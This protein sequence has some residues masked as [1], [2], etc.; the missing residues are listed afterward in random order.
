MTK[1][2]IVALF[3]D[4]I[5]LFGNLNKC[6]IDCGQCEKIFLHFVYFIGR[7]ILMYQNSNF[8]P[9]AQGNERKEIIPRSKDE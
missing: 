1:S 4:R 6:E 2:F 9:D 3:D 5:F 7:P 8:A